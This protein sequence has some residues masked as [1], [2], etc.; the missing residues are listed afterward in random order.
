[1]L[2]NIFLFPIFVVAIS[3]LDEDRN[4]RDVW[5]QDHVGNASLVHPPTREDKFWP[6][7]VV[8][9]VMQLTTNRS[10]CPSLLNKAAA[11][12]SRLRIRKLDQAA[13]VCGLETE[14]TRQLHG[15]KP[16]SL[17][18]NGKCIDEF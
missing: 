8:K 9:I 17:A 1:M 5:I 6:Q 12:V 4:S 3:L 7:L 10:N 13:L 18:A 2:D 16:L 14:Q 15:Q 11:I